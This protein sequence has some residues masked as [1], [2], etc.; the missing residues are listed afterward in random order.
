MITLN[1]N[2]GGRKTES[3]SAAGVYLG[4]FFNPIR[5]RCPVTLRVVDL[6]NRCEPDTAAN[7]PHT[8]T[9]ATG[10]QGARNR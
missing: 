1:P 3:S 8:L 6:S 10:L 9:W 7:D 2:G 4:L 5:G